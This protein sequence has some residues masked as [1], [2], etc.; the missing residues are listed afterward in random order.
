MSRNAKRVSSAVGDIH[1]GSHAILWYRTD[2]AR[3]RATVEF[4]KDGDKKDDLLA[5]ILPL[6]E[7]RGLGK[8]LTEEGFPIEE[9]SNDGRLLMFASYEFMPSNPISNRKLRTAL[10][11]LQS[12]AR[13]EDRGVSVISGIGTELLGQNNPNGALAIERACGVL[14][15]NA[16]LLCLYD[17]RTIAGTEP[18]SQARID[19]VHTQSLV[20]DTKGILKASGDRK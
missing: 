14:G 19:R 1:I 18:S 13:A 8:T 5:V 3:N 2:D 4:L 16:R 15:A 12:A 7:M 9:A 11:N 10:G 6:P 17:A 20:E